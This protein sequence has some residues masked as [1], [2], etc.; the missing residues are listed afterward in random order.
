MGCQVRTRFSLCLDCHE[1][2][3]FGSDAW[4]PTNDP[5]IYHRLLSEMALVGERHPTREVPD[6]PLL[7]VFLPYLEA[8]LERL[9]TQAPPVYRRLQ[10]ANLPEATRR[11]CVDVFP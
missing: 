2:L 11:H 3:G 7:G 1:D 5:V 9:R 10:A 8:D 6:R 4:P